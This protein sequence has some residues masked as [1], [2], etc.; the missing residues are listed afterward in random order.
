MRIRSFIASMLA[1]SVRVSSAGTSMPYLALKA[2]RQ[3]SHWQGP[4]RFML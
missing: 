1:L 2:L 3:A 4:W